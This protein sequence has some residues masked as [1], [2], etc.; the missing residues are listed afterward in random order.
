[1]SWPPYSNSIS[2]PIKG[3]ASQSRSQTPLEPLL[4]QTATHPSRRA[5]SVEMSVSEPD[6]FHPTK[7]LRK[8]LGA[9]VGCRAPAS[10]DPPVPRTG[11][12]A[13]QIKLCCSLW[14]RSLASPA[15]NRV[16]VQSP[17]LSLRFSIFTR[18]AD[19]ITPTSGAPGEESSTACKEL[20]AHS[21]YSLKGR[22][23]SLDMRPDGRA[24]GR[25]LK[26]RGGLG[27]D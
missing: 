13:F 3:K 23:H 2:L 1:M 27:T 18:E 9:R 19:P 4:G 16:T 24:T 11:D 14:V 5:N 20:C 8:L 6:V 26:A 25:R 22:C 12:Q 17:H 7:E 15:S 21:Y 10:L